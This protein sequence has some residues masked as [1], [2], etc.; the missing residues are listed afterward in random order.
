MPE[1]KHHFRKGRMNKDLDERLLPN[2]EYRD[3]QNIEIATSEG[4][5]V[6]AVQN[7][8]GTTLKKGRDYNENTKVLVDWSADS[9][10]FDLIDPTCVG[11]HV[12]TQNNN[13]YWFIHYSFLSEAS[14]I[15]KGS[16]IIQYDDDTSVIQPV[17]VDIQSILNFSSDYLITGI[18]VI[19]N[20]LLWTDNQTQPKKINISHFKEGTDTRVGTDQFKVQSK[21]LGINF[22]EKDISV[23]KLSPNEKPKL[24]L[25]SS[26][27]TGIGTALS[28]IT[29]KSSEP[30]SFK[31]LDNANG[32]SIAVGSLLTL[33]FTSP[34]NFKKTDIL[35]LTWTEPNEIEGNE[36]YEINVQI[37]DYENN[38]LQTITKVQSIPE[39][40][41]Y[42]FKPYE[43]TLVEEEPLFKEKMVRFSYRWKYIDG[44]Y[45]T[46]APFS[47]IAFIPTTFKYTSSDGNNIG[48]SQNLRE[49][50]IQSL[51]TPPNG[52]VEVDILYK[53][54]NNNNVY[55]VDRIKT[56]DLVD[57]FL[58]GGYNIVNE[59]VGDVV[60]SNQILRPWDNVPLKA[61]SQEL[62]A[63]RILYGNYIQGYNIDNNRLPIIQ[64][65]V[66]SKSLATI[67]EPEKSLKSQRTYQVGVAY[68]DA[69]S[70][71][72][73]VFSK[74][75]STVTLDK[76]TADK[77]NSLVTKLSNLAPTFATHFKHFVKETSSEYYNI[78]LDRYYLAEDG[79]IW[80]SFPSSERN[81]LTEN[82]YI[83]LKKRHAQDTFVPLEA[84]YKVLDIKNEVPEY[85]S[86]ELVSKS[87]AT[88]KCR[89]SGNLLLNEPIVK[90]SS[91][92]FLGPTDVQNPSFYNSFSSS[93]Y[94]IIT[95]TQ[96][97]S[98][99]GITQ[100]Y[101]LRKGGATGRTEGDFEIYEV[102]LRESF[103]PSDQTSFG[104]YDD[105]ENRLTSYFFDTSDNTAIDFKIEVLDKQK[106]TSP[107]FFGRFFVK[108]NRDDILDT[109]IIETFPD[110]STE[111]T[112]RRN[113]NVVQQALSD[114]EQGWNL[115]FW[116][117]LTGAL[118]STVSNVAA[119]IYITGKSPGSKAKKD[120]RVDWC[121]T[122]PEPWNGY[123]KT[124]HDHPKLG[125]KSM[126][127]YM[128][129][130]DIP[131][132]K[133]DK[134]N[135]YEDLFTD[136]FGKEIMNAGTFIQ[137]ENAKG[138]KG[139]IYKITNCVR[140]TGWRSG[141]NSRRK[142]TV[143]RR[144]EYYIDFEKISDD[145]S[146]NSKGFDDGFEYENTDITSDSCRIQ[147][148]HIMRKSMST[149]FLEENDIS[150][151]TPAI[152]EVE[153]KESVDLDIY[154]EIGSAIPI[155][156]T[157][158]LVSGTNIPSGTTIL[159]YKTETNSI[160]ISANTTGLLPVSTVL[161]LTDPKGVYSF[162]LTTSLATT[163]SGAS[164]IILASG[165][166][167][168]QMHSL[169]FF[170][171]YSFGQG[172]ESNRLRDDYNAI[173]LD[174]GPI[175][176]TV[177]NDKYKQEHKSNTIIWS[178]LF[179]S[180]G[181][182][183][184][185][186][187][188]IQAEKITKDINPEYG[189][190]QKL[191]VRD[192]DLIA[193][194][195][196]KVLRI[197]A[198]KDAL[199]NADGN[200]NLTSTNNVLGQAM[201]Y[202]G[203]YGISK[204]PESF[205]SHAY[206]IYFADKA[207]AAVLRLSRD[208]LT[209]IASK[210][211]T[212]WFNDN[213]PVSSSIIGS[214][215]ERKGSYNITLN[216]YTLSF[217]ERVDGWT[218]FK[219][220]LPE[221][222]FS[223][224]NVYYTINKGYLHAH[225]NYRRNSF[226][227]TKAS[228]VM[229]GGLVNS[230][231]LKISSQPNVKNIKVGDYVIGDG[232]IGDVTV[233]AITVPYNATARVASGSGTSYT[234]DTQVGDIA[235]GNI[236]TGT[237]ISTNAVVT[238]TSVGAGDDTI[239][240]SSTQSISSNVT[241]TFTGTVPNK[242]LVTDVTLSSAQNIGN[243]TNLSFITTSKTSI[244]LLIND[245]PSLVKEYKTLSYEGSKSSSYDYSGTI[246][247]DAY[248][249]A[250]SSNIIIPIGTTL[251]QLKKSGY[252]SNQIS[253]LT[254]NYIRGW[255]S[256]SIK[257]NIQTG[258]VK[259]FT[260]KEGLW[261][262]FITGD[263]T[264]YSNIDPKEL[265][266]Q[267]LGTFSTITNADGSTANPTQST[268][269]I[270][271]VNN[272]VGGGNVDLSS[273]K[274]IKSVANGASLSSVDLIIYPNTGYSILAGNLSYVAISGDNIQGIVFTQSG[275]NVIAT[276]SFSSVKPSSTASW[277][278]RIIA[279]G[280]ANIYTV[281]G[282]YDTIEENTSTGSMDNIAYTGSGTYNKTTN[283]GSGASARVNSTSISSTNALILD[284]Q[285]GTIEV[286]HVVSGTG[287]QG[288]VTVTAISSQ[289][290]VTLSSNQTLSN[291]V[292]LTFDQAFI[293]SPQDILVKIFQA[294]ADYF[295]FTEPSAFI[296][297]QDSSSI[298]SYT[299]VNDWI[300]TTSS[301]SNGI[302][303]ASQVV[304]TAPNSN[305]VA[306]MAITG[307]G[308]GKNTVVKSI[309]GTTLIFADASAPTGSAVNRTIPATN[310]DNN[311]TVLT[312]TPTRVTFNVKYVFGSNNPIFD[313]LTFTARAIEV[314]DPAITEL[315]A[316]IGGSKTIDPLGESIEMKVFGSTGYPEEANATF[317]FTNEALG[318]GTITF[319]QTSTTAATISFSI[320]SSTPRYPMSVSGT[321]L[322]GTGG[323]A[324]STTV[325]SISFSDIGVVTISLAFANN[326][327]ASLSAPTGTITFKE[328]WNET[329]DV[330]NGFPG[331]QTAAKTISLPDVGFLSITAV[332]AETG[333]NLI[334][335]YY[336]RP[337][338][339]SA[340]FSAFSGNA[341]MDGTAS[342]YFVARQR[343][344][345]TISI[346]PSSVIVDSN[347]T[348]INI[349]S[350][351][352]P[353]LMASAVAAVNGATT[354][355][356][357]IVVDGGSS[358]QSGTITV[359]MRVLGTGVLTSNYIVV[360]SVT[361]QQNFSISEAVSL[362][363]DLVLTFKPTFPNSNKIILAGTHSEIKP[364]MIVVGP[365]G[366][367][368]PLRSKV[369]SING[370][371]LTISKDI[372]GS[373]TAGGEL[374]L[375]NASTY[376]AYGEPDEDS[377]YALIP[378][379]VVA[380]VTGTTTLSLQS[381]SATPESFGY[382]NVDLVV[383]QLT[384]QNIIVQGGIIPDSVI[385]GSVIT[386]EDLKY[387]FPNKT[388]TVGVVYSRTS[389]SISLAVDGVT[390]TSSQTASTYISS[391]ST[392]T[393]EPPFSWD[394]SVGN[395]TDSITNS[396][397][398]NLNGL[399]SVSRYGSED[400]NIGLNL[401]NI[402][403]S[404][405]GTTNTPAPAW[406][407]ILKTLNT[408][409]YVSGFTASPK[410]VAIG[411]LTSDLITLTGTV[412]GYWNHNYTTQIHLT[413]GTTSFGFVQADGSSIHGV[414][415]PLTFTNITGGRANANSTGTTSAT[416]SFGVKLANTITATSTLRLQP[417][418]SLQNEI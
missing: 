247:V 304:L 195:E 153:P 333:N 159:S 218:S 399:M 136:P 84:R 94:I 385:V 68:L 414:D 60:E 193:F 154:H 310:K 122:D 279:T 1:L 397:I 408:Y 324:G 314:F 105:Q 411:T 67:G 406:V 369:L 23:I 25:S 241:L 86:L 410:Q 351:A 219:S 221:S 365:V 49:L 20:L 298:S 375:F 355:S 342:A 139:S 196:D 177:L 8:L 160:I 145:L 210:G 137:F 189:S 319:S 234:I 35:K 130:V 347:T 283:V 41:P 121:W 30:S 249:N 238:I 320:L 135:K 10:L 202:S 106:K 102:T 171:C 309:S 372:T 203:E 110:A 158:L 363:D 175:V 149:D 378:F 403:S 144:R 353:V 368:I 418:I 237:G 261:S 190:I 46:F 343:E 197:L 192:T 179:N 253:Q 392:L 115:N 31:T 366:E 376:D 268:L 231:A 381:E 161:T 61:K 286:G 243:S 300:K 98:P 308:M 405:G 373:V 21:Y 7:V 330:S 245:E 147:S 96:A 306:G 377:I 213:L 354:N 323:V 166:V 120:N 396:K 391:G 364:G 371:T 367:G 302:S 281:A 111:F 334:Y 383:S 198:N 257:T 82:D 183:N 182:T 87:S 315:T 317:T 142:R 407:Y 26:K 395:L 294:D 262:N 227:E 267:G 417:I 265:S 57:N 19:D 99:V 162:N 97:G 70:R 284:S 256:D 119:I 180:T 296:E 93:S 78:A 370:K 104:T 140:K 400:L 174:K 201:P 232:I 53:E 356:S 349:R 131:G 181:G 151:E 272:V 176:S 152:F 185:L 12:D 248:G 327:N 56:I 51:E 332:Y 134:K 108:I 88:V 336:V 384:Y 230:T 127:I 73:P 339:P 69:Y 288:V 260:E 66:V 40:V 118:V 5:N 72:T 194:C 133:D 229:E 388:F 100:R 379:K 209:D 362:T 242:Q 62:S 412:T 398:Y 211:M 335:S 228:V 390:L 359:G 65:N 64:T 331:W 14:T 233:T 27:R 293:A 235:I 345:P 83:I 206:R 295:F 259:R 3:A 109:S 116:E 18:N 205:I 297:E 38:F 200:T 173:T 36:K 289:D 81:K 273:T 138:K 387:N 322:P 39:D 165:Q 350:T 290:N 252:N 409:N 47:D 16:A 278:V 326:T 416:W 303:A 240:L 214:Y 401:D 37:E 74:K 92:E 215:N 254:E 148:I 316:F 146:V 117:A 89:V 393:F 277:P 43:V 264:S 224:N 157:G 150:S 299:I 250:L 271:L 95:T 266:V 107:E 263:T 77:S 156:K 292:L 114:P 344:R 178:G 71:E 246:S 80:L 123:D 361:D 113:I 352:T 270:S 45:S 287:I 374:K 191:H 24:S 208:G 226:Y 169:D 348:A 318:S 269:T 312:F 212:D 415:V 338:A 170:N 329:V 301:I 199:Y 389:G 217:D 75:D 90:G 9:N 360:T 291:D 125:S 124:A 280:I 54:S 32:V 222:G 184:N 63:N 394:F 112:S 79:N 404:S 186:N 204:N 167:H 220:F 313:K 386:S 42:G 402:I 325:S 187:Q 311:F 143:G 382:G 22:T 15:I 168:G 85:I 341:T 91:F 236:V 255:S 44:E 11:Y 282:T 188:F 52:V 48:M 275:K 305:I 244:D 58:D 207:R 103:K 128:A 274:V 164:S 4:S 155:I 225:D 59:I 50:K 13:I 239:T 380:E 141:K 172:V 321:N 28:P 276:I 2:G 307:L 6:G 129:G 346:N 251:D 328:Y 34:P 216:N 33:N 340:L 357:A 258:S 358:T 76:K 55:V 101:Q 17:L 285:I 223:L 163:A 337:I 413:F 132:K 126:T 29:I